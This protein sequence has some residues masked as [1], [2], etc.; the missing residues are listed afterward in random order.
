MSWVRTYSDISTRH[1]IEDILRFTT[2]GGYRRIVRAARS[3]TLNPR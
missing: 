1:R 2:E 3:G